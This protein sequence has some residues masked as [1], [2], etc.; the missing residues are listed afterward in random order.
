ML[1]FAYSI[2]IPNTWQRASIFIS[3]FAVAP[4][5]VMPLGYLA[6]ANDM[7]GAM[8]S[9]Q[10]KYEFAGMWIASGLIMALAAIMGIWGVFSI[11]SL[12]RAAF[13]ARQ[14]GHY[15]LRKRL[16]SGGMGE[17]Y[18][19][20]HMMLKRPCAIKL[21]RPEKAG[22]PA[23]IVRFER[24]VRATATLSHWN[25]VDVFDY[26]RTDDGTF[27][28][29]MEYLP[30]LNVQ[31]LVDQGGPLPASRIIHLMVQV[32]DALHEAHSKGLVHRDIKPA[33]IFAAQR[34]G[35]FDV[36]KLLDFG[37]VL[38]M[39][40]SADTALTQEGA[41]QG[42]PLYLSPE[43]AMAEASD[44]R[45]DIYSLGA[46]MYF[47]MTGKPPFDDMNPMRVIM[48]HA[49]DPVRRPA[50]VNPRVDRQLESV[51]LRCLEKAPADRFP[52][53]M[54]LK[55]ALQK[56][57]AAGCWDHAHADQWWN[58]NGC[59]DKKRMDDEVF[60]RNA[61]EVLAASSS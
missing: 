43:Q 1:L 27:Y 2:F 38:S 49:R 53:A 39:S 35:L 55:S 22:T 47:L 6:A 26:G 23:N 30:G 48:G 56:C 28:Y 41:I 25:S 19:A 7:S 57:D 21:I 9:P 52:T 16:G 32:C 17:V 24:E 59:P 11:R 33:N 4:M 50:E 5:L 44:E 18:M 61:R 34:G 3:I 54:E 36:A 51:V 29:V 45:S 12:R 15:R 42:S 46:V 40:T 37:L 20:E 10:L 60:K 31:Q 58:N 14:F 13:E 8:M